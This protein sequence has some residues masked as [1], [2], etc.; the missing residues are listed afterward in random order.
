MSEEFKDRLKKARSA[1][2]KT[3]AQV[4]DY[5]DMKQSSYSELETGK[6]LTS[7][8]LPLIAK[9][10]G[11]DAYWLQT[12]KEPIK[13]DSGILLPSSAQYIEDWDS[14]TPLEDDEVEIKF[15]K[16]FALACGSGS[17]GEALEGEWRRLRLSKL[18]LKMY[19]VTKENAVAMTAIGHSMSPTIKNK[20]TVFVDLGSKKPIDGK[21]YAICHGGL[22]KF[23]YL[24][25]LPFGGLRIVSENSDEYPEER[26][27]AQEIIDQE[28]HVIGYAFNVQNSLP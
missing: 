10:L 13:T 28:F 19:G 16:D 11:V 24:Y 4:A 25:N 7:G 27:T 5:V 12:G 22:F 6:S 17:I 26:L 8:K 2:K 21:I 15:F 9:F 3:Q 14:E 1:A 18:T 20:A 23:K